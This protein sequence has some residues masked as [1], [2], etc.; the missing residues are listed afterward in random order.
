MSIV[1]RSPSGPGGERAA[2]RAFHAVWL[3]VADDTPDPM[4]PL[5]A[6]IGAE[7]WRRLRLAA[8][9]ALRVFQQRGK[10]SDDLEQH[11]PS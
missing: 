1:S 2:I 7:P 4:P 11:I 10:F 3:G 8:D 6:L 9:E 5:G